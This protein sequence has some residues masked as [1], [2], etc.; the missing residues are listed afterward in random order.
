MNRGIPAVGPRWLKRW[1]LKLGAGCGSR[2]PI[3]PE[4]FQSVFSLIGEG[5][6]ARP[7]RL[8][9]RARGIENGLSGW[10][11]AG[12]DGFVTQK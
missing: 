3:F 10:M 5:A 11:E 9:N 2:F 12:T 4:S 7:S 6:V 1:A 8:L